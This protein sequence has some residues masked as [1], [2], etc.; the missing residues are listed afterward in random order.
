MTD[1]TGTDDDRSLRARIEEEMV[2]APPLEPETRGRARPVSTDECAEIRRRRRDGETVVA[3]ATDLDINDA[4]VSRHARGDERCSH[5][6]NVVGPPVFGEVTVEECAIIRL[7]R[8]ANETV[9]AI[10]DDL[11]RSTA[12]VSR[13]ATGAKQ[14]D[15]DPAVVGPAV[16]GRY[17]GGAPDIEGVTVAECAAIRAR[18]RTGQSLAAMAELL[19]RSIGTVSAHTRGDENQCSHD[20]NVVGP[21][22]AD[23]SS[24][25]HYT[26]AEL[27]DALREFADDHD[28]KPP[29][30]TEAD[31]KDEFPATAT[32][33]NH[34][35]SWNAA[36]EAAGFA[37]RDRRR[38]DEELL[39][40]LRG[41][42]A[43]LDERPTASAV[44]DR[45]EM[46]SPGTYGNRFGSW[47]EALDAA[48][49]ATFDS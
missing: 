37:P 34:F 46:A 16:E 14:C 35:G 25:R 41:L 42:A 49:L 10:A 3:I 12:A 33:A 20:P 8:R 32:F 47:N 15:H 18:R 30:F 44:A 24:K 13:H 45:E 19:D 1:D 39:D 11:G 6:P 23:A 21:P 43:E 27:L 7:R 29:T 2:V 9:T 17:Y 5:D 26:D 38:T 48:G 28:G 40:A 22:L 36:I 31:A 4:T